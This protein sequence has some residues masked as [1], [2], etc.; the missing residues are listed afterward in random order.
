VLILSQMGIDFIRRWI[1]LHLSTRIN[2]SLISDFLVKLMKLPV[3]FFDTKLT[4]DILQSASVITG[5]LKH[6]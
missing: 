3:G 5:G 2:I 4:G 1:L 6:S